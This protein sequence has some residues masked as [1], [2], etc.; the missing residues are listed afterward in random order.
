MDIIKIDTEVLDRLIKESPEMVDKAVR[1]TAFG[2]EADAK[3]LAAVDTGAMRASIF[4]VTS[5]SNGFGAASSAA[6]SKR[7]DAEINDPTP[8][9]PPL[10]TA[11]VAPG[12]NYAYYVEF[13]TG[14]M[15]AQ[16]FM[17]PAVEKADD[18]FSK[19][20]QEIFGEFK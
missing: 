10:M 15:A 1:A 2:V 16:P 4:T 11:Y 8:G 19:N 20:I 3:M 12:V 17:T 5:K 6:S 14:K 13:G 18:N 9:K 7:P